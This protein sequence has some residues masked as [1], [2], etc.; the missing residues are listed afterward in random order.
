MLVLINKRW[1][2]WTLYANSDIGEKILYQE[3]KKIN[4]RKQFQNVRQIR[5]NVD[6]GNY[7]FDLRLG[8]VRA[9]A[10][11]NSRFGRHDC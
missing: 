11:A 4:E 3:K 8:G 10:V 9:I 1:R 2:F 5:K 6:D 7:G